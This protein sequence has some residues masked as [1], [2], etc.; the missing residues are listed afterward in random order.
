M[1]LTFA[2]DDIRDSKFFADIEDYYF[3]Q[4]DFENNH[5]FFHQHNYGVPPEEFETDEN[6]KAMVNVIATDIDVDGNEFVTMYEG[7]DYPIFGTMIHPEKAVSSMSK[8]NNFDHSNEGVQLNRYFADWFVREC[9]KND[10]RYSYYSH[11]VEALI[12]NYDFFNTDTYYG[13]IYLFE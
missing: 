9:K 5:V 2:I 12:G 13:G 3:S 1:P 10:N 4:E 8:F 11:E 7:K 6:L